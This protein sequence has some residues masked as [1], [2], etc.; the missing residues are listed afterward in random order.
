MR[1]KIQGIEKLSIELFISAVFF[2]WE[3][4]QMFN[5]QPSDG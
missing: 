2:Q 3:N 1:K 4:E 5:K